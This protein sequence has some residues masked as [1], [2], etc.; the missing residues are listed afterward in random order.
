MDYIQ[1][2]SVY[3][4]LHIDKGFVASEYLTANIR[5]FKCLL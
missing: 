2:L 3:P 4:F 1:N 5:K